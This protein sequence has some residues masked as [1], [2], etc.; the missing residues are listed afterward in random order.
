MS[1][2]TLEKFNPTL[3]CIKKYQYLIF[4]LKYENP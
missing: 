2:F 3:N 4:N 1:N